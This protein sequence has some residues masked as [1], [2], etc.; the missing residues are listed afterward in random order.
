MKKVKQISGYPPVARGPLERELP[1][2]AAPRVETSRS[3][4]LSTPFFSVG[5]SWSRSEHPEQ[6]QTRL[7][8]PLQADPMPPV[9]SAPKP[10]PDAKA[11]LRREAIRRQQLA[12]LLLP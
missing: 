10:E 12:A 9:N 11:R 7:T 5:F 2:D 1:P 8:G 6:T 4:A 3:F